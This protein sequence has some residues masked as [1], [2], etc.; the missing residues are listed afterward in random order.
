MHFQP[1]LLASDAFSD[2][3]KAG[4]ASLVAA[5]AL[6]TKNHVD[7]RHQREIG[8][9][10]ALREYAEK[11][12]DVAREIFN[13]PTL[14]PTYNVYL[15]YGPNSHLSMH[16]DQNAC[17]YTIDYCV[18]ENV[19]WPLIV[20]GES[21][22]I[23][24]GRSLAFMGG[25]DLHGREIIPDMEEVLVENIMFH[26]CPADHWYFTEGPEYVKVLAAEG[27]LENY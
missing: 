16:K 19:D 25:H 15:K 1:V 5:R 18:S 14:M 6:T 13:D 21:F 9:W 7:D 20:E 27:K 24:A 23:P 8:R 10:K 3:D 22:S 11:L 17:V 4:I 26:F 12:T 2:E